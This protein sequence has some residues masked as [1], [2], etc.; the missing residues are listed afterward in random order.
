M[1]L[2]LAL[3]TAWRVEPFTGHM[4]TA[5]PVPGL[6]ASVGAEVGGWGWSRPGSG[7]TPGEATDGPGSA[8]PGGTP[9][10]ASAVPQ[11]V[12]PTATPAAM[13]T[14]E[15]TL[16]VAAG[17][18]GTGGRDVVSWRPKLTRSLPSR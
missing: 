7:V 17:S 15:M 12:R 18:F 10:G 5:P 16:F 8:C 14:V 6:A 9:A 13:R 4:S 2:L 1:S 3:S 11:A